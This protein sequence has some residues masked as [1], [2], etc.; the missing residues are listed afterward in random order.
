[1]AENKDT[2]QVLNALLQT[3]SSISTQLNSLSAKVDSLDKR[4]ADSS[5]GAVESSA[6]ASPAIGTGEPVGTPSLQQTPSTASGVVP[7][8]K[9]QITTSK[10]I[11]TTYPSQNGIEPVPMDWGN[12]DPQKRGPVIVSRGKDTVK[13]RNGKPNTTLLQEF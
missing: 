13:K 11:L 3:V 10:I 12:A 7:T 1:M 6:P 9:S 2:A 8:K 5:D 4:T